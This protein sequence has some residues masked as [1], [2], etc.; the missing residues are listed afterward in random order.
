[1]FQI[2]RV[3]N[4]PAHATIVSS[5]SS[6][7]SI[8]PTCRCLWELE[9]G[10]SKFKL[11]ARLHNSHMFLNML[12]LPLFRSLATSLSLYWLSESSVR[13]SPADNDGVS[14]PH[15]L[16]P[17]CTRHAWRQHVSWHV[18][19]WIL[20]AG[21]W[22]RERERKG[23]KCISDGAWNQFTKLHN[24][25]QHVSFRIYKENSVALLGIKM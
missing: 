18:S 8:F 25:S 22:S 23:K 20:S 17:R 12:S 3:L 10:T 14:L 1:M 2:C 24:I 7:S 19:S 11:A 15:C 5:L 13:H 9:R 21:T 16:A 4:S 6:S